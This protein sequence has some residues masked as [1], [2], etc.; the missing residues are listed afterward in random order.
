MNYILKLLQLTFLPR[1]SDAGL[2]VLRLW[3]GG[4]ILLLHGWTKLTGFSKIAG[5]FPDPLGLGSSTSLA[6]A[7]FAEAACALLIV[8]G[9]FTRLA[10]AV[11]VIL[12]AVAFFIVHKASLAMGPG[13][14]ELAFVYLGAF[15]TLLI[16]GGGRFS[17]DAKIR[18]GAAE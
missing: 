9:L 5:Q 11:L 2:L 6:L 3:T 18:G 4:A 17:L 13:S 10:A 12:M 7:V 1:S 16:A 14:G 8:L 15:L